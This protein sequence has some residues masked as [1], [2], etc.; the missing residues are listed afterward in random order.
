MRA[1]DR[2]ITTEK[3][4]RIRASFL[5]EG[6]QAANIDNQTVFDIGRDGLNELRQVSRR[7][8]VY[9]TTLFSEA[10]KDLDRVLQTKEENKKLDKSIRSF[11][12]LLAPHFLTKPA[13]KALEWL[14]RRFRIQE[15]NARDILAAFFPYH[16]TKAFLTLLTIITFDTSDMDLFGFLVTQRKARRL[17][18]RATLMAQ[19]LRDRSLMAFICN[20]VF[21][22]TRKGFDYP[23]LHSFYAMLMSQY[24]GQLPVVENSAVQFVLPYV[25]DGIDFASKDAQLAAYLVLGSLASRVTF[26]AEALEKTL[27]AVAQS[28]KDVKAMT[29]CLIQLMQTQVTAIDSLLSPRFLT[30]L[31]AHKDFARV[32]GALAAAFDIELFMQP[33][34][35]SLAHYSFEDTAVS[36]FLS[37]LIPAL[38]SRIAPLLCER[39][40]KELLERD[41]ESENAMGILDLLQLR[42]QQQ[43]EDAIGAASNAVSQNSRLG[44]RQKEA[45]HKKLYSLKMRSGAGKS[46]VSGVLPLKETATTLFLSMNHADS[47]IRLVAAKAL[48]DIVSGKNTEFSLPAEDASSLILERLDQEDDERVLDVVLSLPLT[49][50]IAASQLVSALS[51]LI[52]SDRVPLA[53]LSDKIVGHILS[54][55][56]SSDTQLYTAVVTAVF[57]YLICVRDTAVVTRSLVSI[58]PSSAVGKQKSGWLAS[59]AKTKKLSVDEAEYNA[60]V[61]DVLATALVK[62]WSEIAEDQNG[63]WA[64]Q[65]G[66][67][68]A[69]A[70]T[71]ALAIGAQAVTILAAKGKV[72]E[73]VMA[74]ASVIKPLLATMATETSAKAVKLDDDLLLSATSSQGWTNLLLGLATD[75]SVTGASVRV[76]IGALSV[77]LSVLPELVKLAPHGWIGASPAAA[78]SPEA[79]Y[80]EFLRTTFI[81]VVSRPS[82]LTDADGILIGRMLNVCMGSDWAQFLASQWLSDINSV[83]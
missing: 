1:V 73:C 35:A 20:G 62:S 40:V 38:P 10:V 71:A 77:I 22:A 65:L 24:I 72:D 36:A 53:G 66:S 33:L 46:G 78:D 31:S 50:Y 41:G 69:A 63:L 12:F 51:A 15:F 81:A 80:R 29:M 42:Y 34:V 32:L 70:R 14:I 47:G 2:A 56:T 11:L 9:A 4:Q 67:G 3:A 37:E 52:E 17:L 43:L 21:D 79:R 16:E 26:D 48:S 64:A 76:A 13:G 28:P 59:L 61:V 19:C 45:M 39:L 30:L 6:G 7:F 44:E 68:N 5:F 27:C 57:P 18:D 60:R 75:K 25:V 49:D 83:A 55:D 74:A 82:D 58:L 54:V 8:D 23:G